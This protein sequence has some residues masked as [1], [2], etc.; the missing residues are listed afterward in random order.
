MSYSRITI[1]LP[2]GTL[3]RAERE[4]R[5]TGESRS[6]LFRRA[7]EALF[8][9][10]RREAAIRSY[11]ESYVAE[12]ETDYEVEQAAAL[13]GFAFEPEDWRQGQSERES[14]DDSGADSGESAE[15]KG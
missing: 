7:L 15:G 6:E 4:R 13:S 8:E 1:S 12:P 11:V 2:E 14:Y 3:A 5:S 9:A 10:D